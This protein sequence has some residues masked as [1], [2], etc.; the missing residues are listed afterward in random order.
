MAVIRLGV[1]RD[2]RGGGTTEQTEFLRQHECEKLQGYLLSRP[3]PAEEL[4]QLLGGILVETV[5][6]SVV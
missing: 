1:G 6:E 5:A 3:I 2:C 4:A